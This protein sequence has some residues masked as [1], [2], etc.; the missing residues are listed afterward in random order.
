M[1]KNE[2]GTIVGGT[3]PGPFVVRRDPSRDSRKDWGGGFNVTTIVHDYDSTGAELLMRSDDYNGN[4][5]ATYT[6]TLESV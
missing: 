3:N 5:E 6:N 2:N 4:G 1:S